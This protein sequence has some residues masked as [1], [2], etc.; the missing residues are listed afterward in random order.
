MFTKMRAALAAE[1]SRADE[2]EKQLAEYRQQAEKE[3]RQRDEERRRRDEERRQR[4]RERIESERRQE[5]ESFM[6]LLAEERRRAE[7]NQQALMA[8]LKEITAQ[9]ARLV[10]RQN[11]NGRSER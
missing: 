8:A 11:G 2:A 5:W 6:A 7:E 3:R 10:E 4:E 1:R 9:V